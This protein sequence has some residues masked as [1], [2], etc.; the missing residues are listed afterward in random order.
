MS[1]R[2]EIRREP[3]CT[4]LT[5]TAEPLAGLQRVCAGVKAPSLGSARELAEKV[6]IVLGVYSY[7]VGP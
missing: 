1:S 6:E 2:Y 3:T 7:G 4:T 5:L